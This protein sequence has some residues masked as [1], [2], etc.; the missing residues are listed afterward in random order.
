MGQPHCVGH[1]RD[2]QI[3]WTHTRFGLKLIGQRM[4]ERFLLLV[5]APFLCDDVSQPCSL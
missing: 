3:L 4:V 5:V 1:D 2:N